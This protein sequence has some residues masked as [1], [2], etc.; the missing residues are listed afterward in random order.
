MLE[1]VR[2]GYINVTTSTTTDPVV[3]VVVG[4]I[5]VWFSSRFL[6]FR[7]SRLCHWGFKI[8]QSRI[9]DVIVF[10]SYQKS[11]FLRGAPMKHE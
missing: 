1:A 3:V 2:L 11:R 6:V 7:E 5:F 9:G 8:F 4:S 10:F